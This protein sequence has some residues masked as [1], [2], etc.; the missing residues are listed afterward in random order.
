MGEPMTAPA[1]EEFDD[2]N[3]KHTSFVHIDGVERV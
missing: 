1:C 3:Y 2:E